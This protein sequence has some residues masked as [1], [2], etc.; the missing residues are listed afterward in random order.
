MTFDHIAGTAGSAADTVAFQESSGADVTE[1]AENNYADLQTYPEPLTGDQN[2]SKTSIIKAKTTIIGQKEAR[3]SSAT[4][5]ISNFKRPFCG[6]VEALSDD[7]QP[8]EDTCNVLL[9]ISMNPIMKQADSL[10]SM[11]TPRE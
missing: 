9:P 5:S 7:G 6:V 10:E 11:V 8:I 3:T 2:S 1:S 4:V